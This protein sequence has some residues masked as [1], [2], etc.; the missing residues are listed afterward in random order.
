MAAAERPVRLRPVGPAGGPD[1][2]GARPARHPAPA[3]GRGGRAGGVRLRGQ[4][5]VR[6]RAALPHPRPRGAGAGVHPLVGHGAG[7][8][9]RGRARGATGKRRVR[10]DDA[11]RRGASRTPVDREVRWWQPD[12]AVD[13]AIASLVARGRR[14]RPGRAPG[15]RGP[16]PAAGR[17]ARRRLPQRGPRLVG[18]RLAGPPGRRQPAR[19][20][21]GAVPRRRLRRDPRAAADGR[22]ARHRPPRDRVRRRRDR[23]GAPRRRV[24]LR[25]PAAAHR[26]GAA[27]PAVGPR[28]RRGDEGG[29]D[30]RGRRRA[31]RRLQHL[32]GGPGAPLLG[33]PT[34]LDGP[35]RAV[36]PAAPRGPGGRCP[37][38]RHVGA[39]LRARPRRGRRAVLRPPGAV[40]EHRVDGPTA[41][42]RA[43]GGRR[44]PARRLG[45]RRRA[46]GRDAAGL[47][48]LGSAGPGAVGRDRHVHVVVPAGLAGRP[49]GHGPRRRGALPVPRSRGGGVLQRAAARAQAGRAARQGDAP[50]PGVPLAAARDLAAPEAAVPGAH[51]HRAVRARRARVRL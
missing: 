12:L 17:R 50:P 45:R 20:V 27:V 1:L 29:A 30:R 28:A 10:R 39:L 37:R 21:R 46:A 31:P 13:P 18:H 24:A 35:A 43:A 16:P 19:D 9:V 44:D 34:R 32:Q 25:G 7:H 51:D 2:A 41:P 33:P 14:R 47:R 40:V 38:H 49:G 15:R 48:R 42:P 22:A 26:A 23:R 36:R 6:Q 4:G 5:A 11:R 8:R 3:L